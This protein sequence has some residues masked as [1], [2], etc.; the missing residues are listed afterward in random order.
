MEF[1]KSQK[2]IK[3]FFHTGHEDPCADMGAPKY[4]TLVRQKTPV[5]FKIQ[6]KF[7]LFINFGLFIHLGYAEAKT[8]KEIFGFWLSGRDFGK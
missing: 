1:P 5:T 2:I 7:G 3:D 8:E 4:K 6:P